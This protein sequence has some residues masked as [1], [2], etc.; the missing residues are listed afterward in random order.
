LKKTIV[1]EILENNI[2]ISASD[3][4][5]TMRQ[6]V[7]ICKALEIIEQIS[8]LLTEGIGHELVA[9]DLRR[10]VDTVAEVTGE[11]VTDDILD[12]VFSTFCV[13]K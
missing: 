5:F 8:D 11:V 10:A 7:V 2:D 1:S 13:G 9:I 4:V 12:I 3:I 6:K